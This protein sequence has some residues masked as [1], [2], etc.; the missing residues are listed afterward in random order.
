MIDVNTLSEEERAIVLARRA[1]NREWKAK[2]RD[3]VKAH[4][5]RFY[6]KHA[7]KPAAEQTK[8]KPSE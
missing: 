7:E 5:E 4:Q 8:K 1:Y 2:N 6:K 3:K